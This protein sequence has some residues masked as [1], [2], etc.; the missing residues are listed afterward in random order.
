M[1]GDK[2]AFLL[3]LAISAITLSSTGAGVE[4]KAPKVKTDAEVIFEALCASTLKNCLEFCKTIQNPITAYFC[5][6]LCETTAGS[7]I[8]AI[9]TVSAAVAKEEQKNNSKNIKAAPALTEP[10]N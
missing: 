1:N 4:R 5:P 2:A 9:P 7:C 6:S 10:S 3:A 8:L